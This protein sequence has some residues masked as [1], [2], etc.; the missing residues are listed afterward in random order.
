[1]RHG[2]VGFQAAMILLLSG[3]LMACGSKSQPSI[4]GLIDDETIGSTPPSLNADDGNISFAQNP[5]LEE[6]FDFYSSENPPELT[7]RQQC[8]TCH[9]GDGKGIPV[10]GTGPLGPGACVVANCSEVNALSDYIETSTPV[11]CFDAC[12]DDMANYIVSNFQDNYLDISVSPVLGPPDPQPPAV[13]RQMYDQFCA[14]CHGINGEGGI[15]FDGQIS[16]G[17]C[18]RVD[19]SQLSQ[20]Y[21]FNTL[22]MPPENTT[23][24]IRE[25]AMAVSQLIVSNFAARSANNI[26]GDKDVGDIIRHVLESAESF[27]ILNPAT[28]DQITL[29]GP[30]SAP[31]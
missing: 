21:N 4:E 7:F 3:A 19:C 11:A 30:M 17:T 10:R 6:D 28:G 9:G 31:E 2:F 5:I 24:C 26:A 1:M 8:A 25:C 18:Q 14:S 23:G 15:G 27:T 20:L 13:Q 29:P 12:A 16:S 22:A